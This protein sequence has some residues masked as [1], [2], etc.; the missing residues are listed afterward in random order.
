MWSERALSRH[1]AIRSSTAWY[2]EALARCR[3]ELRAHAAFVTILPLE[4]PDP[5]GALLFPDEVARTNR[6]RL[7]SD[8]RAHALGRLTARYFVGRGNLPFSL[9]EYGKPY[10]PTGVEFSISHAAILVS[11]AFSACGPIGVDLERAADENLS[12]SLYHSVCHPLEI[13]WLGSLL[14]D[15]RSSSFADL[16]T[17]KEALLKAEGRGLIDDLD[18]IEVVPKSRNGSI[19]SSGRWRLWSLPTGEQQVRCTV[20]T[21]PSI[22]RVVLLRSGSAEPF[23]QSIDPSNPDVREVGSTSSGKPPQI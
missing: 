8:R 14:H 13:E 17:R 15:R 9:T 20:A 11:V 1:V 22:S 7:I 5:P 16:W 18:T 10:M 19:D 2:V 23:E 4:Y 6:Y 3:A 21:A 12:P